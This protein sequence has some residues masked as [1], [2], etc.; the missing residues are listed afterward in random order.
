MCLLL[1]SQTEKEGKGEHWRN[2]GSKLISF[3][4]I[5]LKTAHF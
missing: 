1:F 5:I 4:I 3:V 2:D